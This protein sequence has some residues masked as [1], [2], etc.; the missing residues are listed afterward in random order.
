MTKDEYNASKNK[1]DEYRLL[2][3]EVSE[4]KHLSNVINDSD[5]AL[6]E[7]IIITNCM[8]YMPIPISCRENVKEAITTVLS[9]KLKELV[10]KMEE[11]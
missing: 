8:N 4:I 9:N 3:C 6:V 1:T 10:K 11:L 7:K 5:N 2:E